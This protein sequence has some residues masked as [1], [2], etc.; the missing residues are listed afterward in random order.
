MI[1]IPLAVA[2]AWLSRGILLHPDE[3]ALHEAIEAAL[4]RDFQQGD[5]V[6]VNLHHPGAYRIGELSRGRDFDVFDVPD[7]LIDVHVSAMTLICAVE[8]RKDR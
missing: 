5:I 7:V 4:P 3:V 2:K 1:E 8:D 6:R